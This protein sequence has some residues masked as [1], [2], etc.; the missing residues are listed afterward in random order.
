MSDFGLL[1]FV[2]LY[3][4]W[5]TFLG[6]MLG[7][8]SLREE[9]GLRGVTCVLLVTFINEQIDS[10]VAAYYREPY[11]T[12][13]FFNPLQLL[14][15]C[16]FFY[17]NYRSEALKKMTVWVVASCILFTMVNSIFFQNIH[18][19]P[20]NFLLLETFVLI[21]LSVILFIE[22][23]DYDYPENIFWNPAFICSLAILSFN[24]F[25]FVWFLL[26]DYFRKHHIDYYK[27]ISRIN[28]FSNI[29][30]YGLLLFAVILSIR[31]AVKKKQSFQLA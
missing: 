31:S 11:I 25:S 17:D 13:H 26:I 27:S 22:K 23:L 5:V 21:I 28:Y 1:K 14:C 19:N 6:S 30:Y 7:G 12:Y 15:L 10:Y 9:K 16:W 8:L 24:I 2:L 20:S 29:L 4:T 18:E 3:I